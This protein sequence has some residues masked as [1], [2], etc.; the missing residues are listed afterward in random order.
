M[1]THEAILRLPTVDAPEFL[2]RR[3]PEALYSYDSVGRLTIVKGDDAVCLSPDD[4][5]DLR[6][7]V[8]RVA[9]LD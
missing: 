6:R 1:N 9:G 3:E 8:A 2:R 5:A 4:L 7:F